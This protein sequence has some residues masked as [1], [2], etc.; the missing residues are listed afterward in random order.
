[1]ITR[2]DLRN[3]CYRAKKGVA[4]DK[5][6]PLLDMIEPLLDVHQRWENF[7]A[8]W[9]VMVK[10]DEVKIIT[11]ETDYDYIHS[12]ILEASLLDRKGIS[13][14]SF[15]DRQAN[16]ITIVQI[17]ML[18]GI[19]TWENYNKVWGVKIDPELKQLQTVM[20]KVTPSQIEVTDEMIKASMKDADGN[21][22]SEQ[23][24][25]ETEL[26]VTP[27]SAE[28]KKEFEKFLAKKQEGVA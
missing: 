8:V 24:A 28:Q 2:S 18:D 9:D 20:Y 22:L 26:E 27:M 11:P 19:M 13:F 23:Q 17:L 21:P 10:D 12:T 25:T 16:I 6:R 1:M 15:D 5:H 7:P 4:Q 14:D 3:A